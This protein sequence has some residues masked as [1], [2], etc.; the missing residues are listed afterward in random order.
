M[1]AAMWEGWKGQVNRESQPVALNGWRVTVNRTGDRHGIAS[2][3]GPGV[4]CMEVPVEFS[5][6]DFMEALTTP[7]AV[8]A[9]LDYNRRRIAE[10]E[11]MLDAPPAPAVP[12]KAYSDDCPDLYPSQPDAWA[13]GWNACRAAMLAQ[14]VS[15]GYKLPE[16]WI[17]CSEQMP[18]D[19]QECLVQTHSGFRYV[20]FY[21]E[22]TGLFY[23]MPGGNQVAFVEH[24][25]VT[26]WMPLPAAP[27]GGNG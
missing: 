7:Q 15:S 20:S 27:E 10:L 1:A 18:D 19:E 21:D 26:H 9:E 8:A 14:P 23:D 2:I 4:F 3:S 22:H 24:I 13:A 12:D 16:G 11:D 5:M 17:A 6:L 25:L